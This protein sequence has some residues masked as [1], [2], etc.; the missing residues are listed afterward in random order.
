M[1]ADKQI[2]GRKK[3]REERSVGRKPRNGS[4][5]GLPKASFTQ[6]F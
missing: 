1:K 6:F 4:F 2:M 3:E 5:L